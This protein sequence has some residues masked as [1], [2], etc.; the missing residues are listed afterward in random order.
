M[1]FNIV[2]MYCFGERNWLDHN[3]W[4]SDRLTH[5]EMIHFLASK[6]FYCGQSR[7]FPQNIL[8]FFEDTNFL[9]Y[10]LSIAQS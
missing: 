1:A 2:S 7:V 6:F 10:I 3:N 9:D 4:A 8:T 5:L